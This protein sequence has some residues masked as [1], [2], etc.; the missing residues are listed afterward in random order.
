MKAR[1]IDRGK[2]H[3]YALDGKPVMGVTTIINK[4]VPK[5][6]L[7]AWAAREAAEFVAAHREILTQLSDQELVDLVKGAPFRERDAA[8][9]R[10]T[11]VHRLS[12][13]LARGLEAIV[14]EPLT[15]HV[16]SY[17]AFLDAFQP[18]DA[19]LER[20]V[21]NRAY[22]YA[23]TLDLLCS[24]PDYGDRCLLD[25]KTNRSGPFG[26]TALQLAAY[27]HAE[28]YVDDQGAE[29]P[30]PSIDFYGVVWVRADGFD[31]YRYDVTERE[32]K[33]FLFCIQT[34][35][36]TENRMDAVRGEAIW[37][38]REVPA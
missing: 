12:E 4:A 28:F 25:I 34:A 13:Q 26:E 24:L 22:R 29:Q 14:P 36:W 32:W 2:G 7:T 19:V 23:G 17:V 11:E 9:N 16:D 5:P 1:R 3:S 33:Q 27:G 15:G 21:F 18:T 20:P 8:A 37:Q 35:W 6:A 10:G 38:R 31:L 30:M